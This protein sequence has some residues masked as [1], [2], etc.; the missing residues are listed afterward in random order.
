VGNLLLGALI[1]PLTAAVLNTSVWNAN[2]GTVALASA[3]VSLSATSSGSTLGAAGPYEATGQQLYARVT[4]A[5]AG[6][7][8]Q[9]VTT[10]MTV[11]LNTSN[12]AYLTCTPGTAWQAVVVNAGVST[13]VNL[14]SFDP[15]LHAWWQIAESG[16]QWLFS[17]SADGAA[18]TQVAAIA[19]S[20]SAHA[21]A[22]QFTASAPSVGGQ[23]AY[24]EH[25]NTP[26]GA[27]SLMPSWPRIR[28]QVAFNTGGTSTAQPAYVDLSSRLR[29]S[30]SATPSG[31]QYELDQVQSG[32]MSCNLWNLD[33]ALDPTDTASP[34]Y[35]NVIPM[36][37]ARLQAVWPPT[38]NLLPRD[39]ASGLNLSGNVASSGVSGQPVFNATGL[40]PAP[41]GHTTAYGWAIPSGNATGA[42]LGLTSFGND[43]TVPDAAAVPVTA[44]LQ[45]TASAW[46]ALAAGGDTALQLKSQIY[47]YSAAGALLSTSNGTAAA[48]SVLGAWTKTSITATAP[49][50]AVCARPAIATTTVPSANTT[51]YLTAW[52]AE[53]AAAATPWTAGGVVYPLWTG[54]VERWPQTWTQQGTYGLVSLTCIDALAGLSQFTLQS[55]FTASLLALGPTM[56]YPLNE[57][58]GSQQFADVTGQR[59]VRFAWAAPNGGAGASV[60]AGNS[61]TG[62]GSAGSS[63]PVVTMS[64]PTP[65]SGSGSQTVYLSAPWAGPFGPPAAGAWTRIICFRTTVTPAGV[66][67]LWLATGPG[68]L[69]GGSGSQSVAALY[70]NSSGK[71]TGY[72]NNAD[73]SSSMT[74]SV[75]DVTVTDGNW[76]IAVM[77]L[78]ADGKQLLVACDQYSYG[79]SLAASDMHPTGCSTDIVGCQILGGS[80]YYTFAGDLAYITEVPALLSSVGDLTGGFTTAWAG[81]TSAA[82]AQR[83]LNLAGVPLSLSTAGAKTA[84]GGASLAGVDAASALALVADT[85]TGQAFV[86]GAGVLWLTGRQWRYL[87]PTAT[88]TFGEQQAGGEV[89]YL[90][91]LAIDFDPTHVYNA[92]TVTN[93][94]AQNSPTQPPAV[95]NSPASQASYLPRTHSRS[96]NA[97]DPAL[98]GSVARYL[99]GQYAQPLPRVPSLTANPAANPAL[100]S[101]LLGLGFGTRAQV[102]RRPPTGPGAAQVTVQAFI[103]RLTWD[104]DDL[105]K[106]RLGLQLTPAAP[107]L[108]WGVAAALHTTLVSPATAGTNTITVGPLN[109]S[110]NNPASAA[111]P[112][113]TILLLGYGTATQ[114]LVFVQSVA[115]TSPGYTSVVL[116]LLTNLGANHASGAVLC[117]QLPGSVALPPTVAAGYPASLDA[118]AT[119]TATGPRAAY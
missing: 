69:G 50:G 7:G 57:P 1:D 95:V 100:W 77:Q 54:Y 82:R 85:E 44:G 21:V 52:Q 24:V 118:P 8:G 12:R 106:L 9:S 11:Q 42:V 45:Y 107:Y 80:A 108:G 119:L 76:H 115:A 13:T 79:S 112:P 84:M 78:T 41:T 34:Y 67:Y 68:A 14:P 36:R 48:S 63:G 86:D 49:A 6:T 38:R 87:Q 53:Q 61:V 75:P 40:A 94:G 26:L 43:F 32:Q 81:E 99:A 92:V 4:P 64:N 28:F 116:T 25:V 27:S 15:A 30:W 91:D 62:A 66:S 97:Q 93:E 33:G 104:G 89:P 105:G 58:S 37:K 23:S 102:N 90:G 29:G 117:D 5:L 10:T 109:G 74:L 46:T 2:A 39:A 72:V 18:W 17:V 31:R 20:W 113:S 110:A 19:Y 111:L 55:S 3:R 59:T 65:G 83:I 56:L 88:V 22:V 60:T 98:A 101:T 51:V 47:W 35:P 114:E 16:G 73:S 96:I 70:I 103:E 71:L